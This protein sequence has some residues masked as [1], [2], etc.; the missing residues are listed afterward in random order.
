MS[1]TDLLTIGKSALFA[2]QT[3]LNVTSQNIANVNT[4]GY[5]GRDVVLQIAGPVVPVAGGYVGMGVSVSGI[6]RRYDRFVAG[7]LL[8]QE[9]RCGKSATMDAVLGNVEQVFNDSGGVGLSR[10]LDQFFSSLQDVSA[11]PADS[12]QRTVLLA[13]AGN[14]VTTAKQMEDSLLGTLAQVD[15]QI[16]DD[17]GKVNDIARKIA[18]LNTQISRIE[19]GGGPSANDLR[20]QRDQLVSQL[21]GLTDIA[22]LEDA[23]GSL[24][25]RVGMRTLVD[26]EAVNALTVTQNAAGETRLALD[27]VDVTSRIAQGSIGGLLAARAEVASGPL[28]G[29]RRLAAA[30]TIEMNRLHEAGYGLDG[31]TGNDLFTP[32]ALASSGTSAAASV[33]SATVVDPAALTLSEYTISIGAGNAY[34]VTNRDSGAVVASGTYATGTPIVFDGISAVVTGAAAAGDTFTVSPLEGAV[35]GFGVALTD[36]RKIAAASDPGAL[37]GDNSNALR[38]AGFA[39]AAVSSLGGA[40]LTGYYSGLVSEVGKLAQDA[41]DLQQFDANLRSTLQ[42]QRDSESGVS[43]DEE[44]MNLVKYQRA[45]EAGAQIIRI[46]DELFQ[47]VLEMLL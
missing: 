30:I 16:V 19:S 15:K 4:P 36:P 29:L 43:L 11:A 5:S 14:L 34:S 22:T 26:G 10:A 21:A 31:T 18:T 8:G 20:D 33:T 12:S 40:T 24:T 47:T 2:N 7:Q 6:E 41:S 42:D 25:V 9:Q 28:A 3:A 39:D 45:Y 37:P 32:L 44:A 23:N 13:N 1:L 38:L 46:T 17:A 35:S 27:G